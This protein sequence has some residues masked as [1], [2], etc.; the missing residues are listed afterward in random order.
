MNHFRVT[1]PPTEGI[2]RA[3]DGWKYTKI[4]PARQHRPPHLPLGPDRRAAG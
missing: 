3:Y 4:R 2:G 1:S